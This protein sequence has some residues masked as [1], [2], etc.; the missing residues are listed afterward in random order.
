M[1]QKDFLFVK[2]KGRQ[3]YENAGPEI[4]KEKLVNNPNT[5]N[6]TMQTTKS[7]SNVFD[8]THLDQ[9]V[10]VHPHL[11]LPPYLSSMLHPGVLY[12]YP[13][14]LSS[15]VWPLFPILSVISFL[16]STLAASPITGA[17]SAV[18]RKPFP[19]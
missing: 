15:T 19:F 5:G 7:G 14:A 1:K 13:Q 11:I 18:K 6:K 3:K 10:V 16:T 4:I 17:R 12:T 8:M 9:A 2:L